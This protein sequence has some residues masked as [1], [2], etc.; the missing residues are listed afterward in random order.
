MDF[1]EFSHREP[2]FRQPDERNLD[3]AVVEVRD[4]AN[5]LGGVSEEE[6]VRGLLTSWARYSHLHIV[7]KSSI[8]DQV[9]NWAKFKADQQIKR[10]D[11][12]KRTQLVHLFC[13]LASIVD[14]L[15]AA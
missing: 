12:S 8:C 1:R 3:P 5:T 11:G 4:E 15:L 14:A 10:T 13:V 7:Q 6:S 2:D 9:L